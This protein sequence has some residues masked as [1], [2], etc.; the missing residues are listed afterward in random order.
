M[1][2]LGDE[3]TWVRWFT[4]KTY[5]FDL[6]KVNSIKTGKLTSNFLKEASD[7]AS[8]HHCFSLMTEETTL[9]LEAPNQ[10]DRDCI[11]ILLR[12]ILNLTADTEVR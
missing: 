1:S 5:S 8:V 10:H 9:D 4:G 2:L 3:F 11:V 12:K 7:P 6:S